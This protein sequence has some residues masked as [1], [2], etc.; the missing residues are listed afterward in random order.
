[1]EGLGDL[2][3][4]EVKRDPSQAHPILLT[5]SVG[6]MAPFIVCLVFSVNE[7]VLYIT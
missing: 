4:R 1:M 2:L 7:K 5:Y 6:C 3:A